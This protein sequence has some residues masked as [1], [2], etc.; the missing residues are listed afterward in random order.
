MDG[1]DASAAGLMEVGRAEAV[2]VVL[3][4]PDCWQNGSLLGAAD[5]LAR[6]SRP[7][8]TIECAINFVFLLT[9][10]SAKLLPG[11]NACGCQNAIFTRINI[12]AALVL[13]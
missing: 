5:L 8:L 11:P 2:H 10:Q 13:P 12:A 7:R 1:E 6:T 9:L 3:L 4:E